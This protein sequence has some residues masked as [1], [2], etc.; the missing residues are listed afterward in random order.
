MREVDYPHER[1]FDGV[2]YLDR[3]DPLLREVNALYCISDTFY[4]L[5]EY[6]IG[7]G[8][9]TRAKDLVESG[10]Q[11]TDLYLERLSDWEQVMLLRTKKQKR[12]TRRKRIFRIF[13]KEKT[14]G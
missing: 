10:H 11:M 5:S 7:K 4:A 9:H 14:D 12:Q 6:Y 8:E 13:K 2:L 1:E 3:Y